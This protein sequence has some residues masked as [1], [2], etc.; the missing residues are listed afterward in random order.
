MTRMSTAHE[1]IGDFQRLLAGVRLR[2]Q[3]I[4]EVHA[5]LA[6]IDRIERVLSVDEG[7]DAALLLRLSYAMQRQRGLARRFG[8]E[9]L[10]HAAARQPADA[11]R[12][13]E[14]ERARGGGL[15]VHS[16]IALH[17]T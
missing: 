17:Q 8:S 9:N 7:A 10:D 3:E 11:E 5:E 12:N 2:D 6:G 14:H 13:V 4:V 1:R 15:D 16:L